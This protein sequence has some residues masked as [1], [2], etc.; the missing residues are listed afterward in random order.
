MFHYAF[1]TESDVKEFSKSINIRQLSS[2][3]F[4]MKHDVKGDQV[5]INVYLVLCVYSC[6]YAFAPCGLQGCKN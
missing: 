1:T 2:G 3:S 5:R 6:S 4:F